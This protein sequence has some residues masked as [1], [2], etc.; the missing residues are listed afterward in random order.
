MDAAAPTPRW[1]QDCAEVYWLGL[2]R[3]MGKNFTHEFI[4]SVS[5]LLS[6]CRVSEA[7][8]LDL[9]INCY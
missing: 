3:L 2:W 4:K 7:R 9:K 8:T 5:S 6:T 1:R